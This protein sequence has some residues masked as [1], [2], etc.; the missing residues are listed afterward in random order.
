MCSLNVTHFLFH[1][2]SDMMNLFCKVFLFRSAGTEAIDFSEY[3]PILACAITCL[4][5]SVA[6]IFMSE[7][8]ICFENA[9]A[10]EYGSSPVEHRT[11]YFNRFSLFLDNF[12][13][14]IFIHKIPLVRIPVKLRH[15]D[16]KEVYKLFE[17]FFVSTRSS[18]Y[19]RH[20]L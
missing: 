5:M 7:S 16:R 2:K 18:L 13:N 9:I 12:W 8:G 14:Y 17:L 10:R 3:N 4:S 19:T 20:S 6:S 15:I 1:P 11:P